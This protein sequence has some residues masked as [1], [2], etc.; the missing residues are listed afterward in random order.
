MGQASRP[1]ADLQVR[2]RGRAETAQLAQIFAVW[3]PL[4]EI[5]QKLHR[6]PICRVRG[7]PAGG[8]MEVLIISANHHLNGL[9]QK[10]D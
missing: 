5:G 1:A 9:Y 2:L 8:E 10:P 4:E 7:L 3:R 6:A